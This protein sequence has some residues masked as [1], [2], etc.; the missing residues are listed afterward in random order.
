M[1]F[2][3]SSSFHFASLSLPR[4]V[5]SNCFPLRHKSAFLKHLGLRTTSYQIVPIVRLNLMGEHIVC[6]EEKKQL[7]LCDICV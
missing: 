1:Y 4:E 6:T 2:V 7:S 3:E 5:D